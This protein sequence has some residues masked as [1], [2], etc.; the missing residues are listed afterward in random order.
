MMIGK[1]TSW[2]KVWAIQDTMTMT[3]RDAIAAGKEIRV[4][5][6]KAYAIHI[7]PTVLVI[8]TASQVF[9]RAI[10]PVPWICACTSW[11]RTRRGTKRCGVGSCGLLIVH[12]PCVDDGHRLGY[13][14]RRACE[15]RCLGPCG[16]PA[17]PPAPRDK[18]RPR[19]ASTGH[20]PLRA[21]TWGRWQRASPRPA[22]DQPSA[23]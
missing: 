22:R 12:P 18:R 9:K 15:G 20:E 8:F 13:L 4:M 6:A 5:A 3:L 1:S 19:R 17:G 14:R 23:P 11:L 7:E 2:R 16:S 21:W 10:G